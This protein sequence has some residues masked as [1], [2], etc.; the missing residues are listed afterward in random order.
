MKIHFRKWLL[1]GFWLWFFLLILLVRALLSQQQT[2]ELYSRGLFLYIREAQDALTSISPFALVYVF[3]GFVLLHFSYHQFIIWRQKRPV[4]KR[5]LHSFWG[6]FKGALALASLFT[7]MWGY[8]YGRVPLDVQLGLKVEPQEIEDLV[9]ELENL[10]YALEGYRSAIEGA[11]PEAM[12]A[13][14]LPKHFEQKGRRALE[15]LLEEW[16]YPSRG[17]VR[18]RLLSPKGILLRFN[19]SGVYL[20]WTGEGHVDAGLHPVQLPF[21]MIHEMGHGYGFTDEGTCNFL[22]VAGGLKS[23]EPF[24]RYAVLLGYWRYLASNVR[25]YAREAY[26]HIHNR[27]SPGILA[28]LKAIYEYQDAY[29]ELFPKLRYAAYDT[30]LRAQGIREGILNYD[31]VIGLMFAIQQ[32]E[33]R[34]VY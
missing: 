30:Y 11:G 5:L 15:D 26:S 7:L 8:N 19:T 9:C 22:A 27:L 20:P 2:E 12:D 16:N 1:E 29:P 33:E 4:W 24:I 17:S 28:D 13:T 31:R 21:V 6:L 23:K 32:K 25:P 10:T 18:A 14:F 3:L 34:S